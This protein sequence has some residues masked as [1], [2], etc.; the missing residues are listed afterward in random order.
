MCRHQRRARYCRCPSMPAMDWSLCTICLPRPIR[1]RLQT[2]AHAEDCTHEHTQQQSSPPQI[3]QFVR[4]H[5]RVICVMCVRMGRD[6][7][8]NWGAYTRVHAY[9][10]PMNQLYAR[11][12][13]SSTQ[14]EG[15][16][17]LRKCSLVGISSRKQNGHG[18]RVPRTK[19][20]GP[21]G[22]TNKRAVNGALHLRVVR[23]FRPLP[24]HRRAT[25]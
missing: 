25:E 5:T 15:G 6:K 21:D 23:D 22:A 2:R 11:C 9:T 8:N 17:C 18:G 10:H 24:N 19:Q 20:S 16:A 1:S 12:I 13:L 14:E 7:R 3:K 4:V